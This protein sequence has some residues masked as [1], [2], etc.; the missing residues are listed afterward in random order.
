MCRLAPIEVN[1]SLLMAGEKGRE[2]NDTWLIGGV[3]LCLLPPASSSDPAYDLAAL[4]PNGA[5]NES[6]DAQPRR[7]TSHEDT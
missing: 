4:T 1:E 6:R 7:L 2:E 3:S 5:P